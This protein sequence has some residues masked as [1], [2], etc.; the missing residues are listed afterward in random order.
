LKDWF[1]YNG[2]NWVSCRLYSLTLN[3]GPT[4]PNNDSKEQA[5][6][7]RQPSDTD[8][9]IEFLDWAANSSVAQSGTKYST[10]TLTREPSG[11]SLGSFDTKDGTSAGTWFGGR[12]T[13]GAASGTSDI[14]FSLTNTRTGTPGDLSVSAVIRY[15]IIGA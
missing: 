3:D 13:I 8:M 12:V 7:P 5:H 4:Q 15:R 6:A 1:Y 2:T 11:T 10:Y 9:L 14:A